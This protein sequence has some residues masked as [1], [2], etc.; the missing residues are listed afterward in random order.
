M[1]TLEHVFYNCNIIQDFWNRTVTWIN[2][3][4]D[5]DVTVTRE[6][7]FLGY[8]VNNPPMAINCIILLGKQFIYK[9]K[10]HKTTTKLFVFVR[11]INDFIIIEHIIASNKNKL[12]SHFFKWDGFL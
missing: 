6:N 7:V 12:S 10:L 8:N 9:C 4:V 1:E 11:N 2:D 5:S 3:K